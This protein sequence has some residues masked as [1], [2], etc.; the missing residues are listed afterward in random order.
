MRINMKKK[1]SIRLCVLLP[2]CLLFLSGCN[3][4]S[5]NQATTA[6]LSITQAYQTV[7]SKLTQA[8]TR[9]PAATRTPV[10][11][12]SGLPT[13]TDTQAAIMDTVTAPAS[14]ATRTTSDCDKAAPGV[15]IDVTI[16]DDTRM[17]PNHTFTKVWRLRNLGTCTWGQDYRVQFFSGEMMGASRSVSLPRVVAPGEDVDIAVEMVAPKEAGTHQ[18]NWKLQNASGEWF[19]IGPNGN[20]P[21]WVRIEVVPLP[22]NTPTVVLETATVT[23]TPTQ[24]IQVEGMVTLSVGD[25]FDLDKNQINPGSDEDLTYELNDQGQYLLS[26]LKPARLGVFGENQPEM[27]DCQQLT[28]EVEALDVQ[29]L[30]AGTY[31]CYRTNL[32]LPGWLLFSGLDSEQPGQVTLEFLTY[33]LP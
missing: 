33:S 7:Q 6:T 16:P 29:E 28:L 5:Q 1:L 22:T 15:P 24:A 26:A 18:G 14:T 12:E 27:E 32:G 19:G 31:I 23:P 25:R 17:Q 2:V 13:P 4:P 9:T 10:P 3:L 30:T 8:V 21:F 20:S 11:T